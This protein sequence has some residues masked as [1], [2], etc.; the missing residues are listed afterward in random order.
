MKAT[1]YSIQ[2]KLA[3]TLYV[4]Q[5]FITISKMQVYQSR[6]DAEKAAAYDR[7]LNLL[8]KKLRN[9]AQALKKLNFEQLS[10]IIGQSE[11]CKTFFN[12]AKYAVRKAR[13]LRSEKDILSAPPKNKVV[14]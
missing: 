12:V 5:N 10:Q 9:Q 8:K 3:N 2:E 13:A 6:E 14:N 11:T 7:L 1:I 4:E